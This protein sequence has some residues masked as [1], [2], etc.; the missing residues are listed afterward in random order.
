MSR[1]LSIGTA[2]AHELPAVLA[3]LARCRL[4][5]AG[6]TEHADTLLVARSQGRIVGCAAL[7]VYGQQG[8]LR[9]VA[10]DEDL[11][12]SGLG[13]DLTKA[14]LSVAS[15]RGVRRVYL[16]TETAAGFFPRFGFTVVDRASVSGAVR[17]SEEFT[18]ACP[19][20]AT[21]MALD[22]SPP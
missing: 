5:E 14:V 22:L 11:R 17:A 2:R 9:S 21:V 13:G 20:T 10:V 3:L 18:T 15:G 8:L 4:P 12:G 16:L 6:L 1:G 7:E 19:T